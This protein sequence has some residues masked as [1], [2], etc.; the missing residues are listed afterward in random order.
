MKEIRIRIVRTRERGRDP[1]TSRFAFTFNLFEN[2]LIGLKLLTVPFY[3]WIE[4]IIVFGALPVIVNT[5]RHLKVV[6][7]HVYEMI[8][9]LTRLCY[10]YER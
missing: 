2:V 9:L 4:E 8:S 10:C 7:Q 3:V 1:S 6:Y 5:A